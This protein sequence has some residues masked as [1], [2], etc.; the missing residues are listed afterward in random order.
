MGA[1]NVKQGIYTF[2]FNQGRAIR[3]ARSAALL[4]LT[5]SWKMADL[6]AVR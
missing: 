6:C 5:S 1:T 2:R 3:S 4:I